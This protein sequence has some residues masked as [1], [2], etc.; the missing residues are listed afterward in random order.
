MNFTVTCRKSWNLWK[1]P[2]SRFVLTI[3][4]KP[5]AVLIGAEAFLALLRGHTPED[6]LL[7]LQLGAWCRALNRE[8][9]ATPAAARRG[10]TRKNSPRSERTSQMHVY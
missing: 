1:N 9:A 7:A 3:H 2:N 8:R 10:R 6:R 4:S 5:K